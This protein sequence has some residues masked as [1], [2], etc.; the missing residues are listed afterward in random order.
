MNIQ[1][2]KLILLDL[3]GTIVDTAQDIC[4]AMNQA[5]V[6]L[7][8]QQV[9]EDQIRQWIGKGTKQ[10]CLDILKHQ[11]SNQD[12]AELINTYLQAYKNNVCIY[13]QPY[14]GVMSFLTFCQKQHYYLACVTNKPYDLAQKLLYQLGLNHYFNLV[15]GGDTLPQRKPDPLPL[16]HAMQ[17]FD[18]TKEQTVMIGDS[19]NDILAAQQAGI[20]CIAVTYGYNHGE[21]ITHPHQVNSLNKLIF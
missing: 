16:Y 8:L 12:V 15:I 11:K 2:K 14:A 18:I 9:T 21:K 5:L 3:D 4:S 6:T 1:H 10:L 19:S 17:Y 13:S 7:N 20:D